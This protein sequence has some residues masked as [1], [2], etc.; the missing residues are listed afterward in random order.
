M[1][2]VLKDEIS[3]KNIN[4]LAQLL[5][6]HC[7]RTLSNKA[8]FDLER[9]DKLIFDKAWSE[10]G[11]LQ[12][13]E[14]VAYAINKTLDL[15][16]KQQLSVLMAVEKEFDGLF[17]LL[18][19]EFVRQ[20]GIQDFP[21]S[22]KAMAAF[23]EK[24]SSEFAMRPFLQSDSEQMLPVIVEWSQSPNLH[25]RRLASESIRP[26]LP[27]A[28]HLSILVENPEWG[29]T[30]IENLKCDTSRYVQKSVANLLNDLTKSHPD[31]VLNL[32]EQWQLSL[33]DNAYNQWIIKHA[34]RT[35]LKQGDSRALALV[36][37]VQPNHINIENLEIDGEVK[38]GDKC[39][40]NFTLS[41][42]EEIGLIRVEYAIYFLRKTQSAYR[43]VFKVSE[44]IVADN[45][46]NVKSCHDFK[47]ISTRKYQAGIHKIDFIINGIVKATGEFELQ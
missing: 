5:Q 13:L 19:A 35:L 21:N 17:H 40:F 28:P 14:R 32:F 38:I 30:I 33:A 44:S 39:H 26:R 47:V 9:F 42:T 15:N 36:G 45:I 46:K 22:I 41:S 37:Y 25:L 18:F 31:W 6:L 7:V 23:T 24:S 4:H 12:R 3:Q 1:S 10:M 16:Y 20:F 29:K 43:K 2:V 27:W 34:L 8:L 11:L